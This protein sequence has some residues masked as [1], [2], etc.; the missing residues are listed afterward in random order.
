MSGVLHV[1]SVCAVALVARGSV[2]CRG[3]FNGKY[4]K[5][6]LESIGTLDMGEY[7]MPMQTNGTRLQHYRRS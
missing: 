5:A 6:N 4:L 3:Y 1:Q 7:N 2:S